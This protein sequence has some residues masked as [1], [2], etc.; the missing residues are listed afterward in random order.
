VTR[1]SIRVCCFAAWLIFVSGVGFAEGPSEAWI[2]AVGSP[3]Y[4]ALYA[5]DLDRS[6]KWYRTVFGLLEL[7][8]SKADDGS[9]R[10]EN[11]GNEQLMVEVIFDIRAQ[12]IDRALGFRKVGFYVPDVDVVADRAEQ[13]TGERP[14][15][16][17]FE[18]L[19]QRILQIPDPDGNI[20]QLI[21]KLEQK[22]EA[23]SGNGD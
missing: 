22:A 19:G 11:L 15:V 7:G 9:W 14:R 8:G 12:G 10:I 23:G 5:E 16:V 1:K 17:D 2:D 4:F 18:L 6:V 3:Q 21:S 20:I 13:A